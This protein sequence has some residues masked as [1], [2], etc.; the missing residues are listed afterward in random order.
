MYN[1]AIQIAPEWYATYSNVGVIYNDMGQYAKAIDPLKKS[2]A[3]RPSYPG[4][5]NLGVAYFGLNKYSEAA[6][7]YQEAAKLDP[8]QYVI[9]GNLGDALF[10]SGKKDQS[11]APLRKAIELAEAELKVNPRDPEV[12]SSTAGYY[13][14][15]GDRKQTVTYLSQ[16]LQYGHNDKDVL[17]EAASAYNHLGESG[18]ALEF[19]AKAAQAGYTSEKIRSMHEFDNLAGMAEYQQLMKSK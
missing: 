6:E 16:A 15:L 11:Y 1:H 5:V 13:A 9:W 8:Q 4:Y 17:L 14:E 10:Y 3:L 7:A 12:L 2:I 18:L 19:L